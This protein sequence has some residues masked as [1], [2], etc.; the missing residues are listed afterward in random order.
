[1][2]PA[3]IRVCASKEDITMG[4]RTKRPPVEP[5]RRLD[6]VRRKDKGESSPQIAKE[7]GYDV[8]TVRKHIEIGELEREAKE[9]R[10][11]VVRDALE[12]HYRSIVGFARRLDK[13][14]NAESVIPQALRDDRMWVALKQH[15]PRSPLW[16]LLGQWDKIHGSLEDLNK[17]LEARLQSEL[18]ADVR[19]QDL[20]A[21]QLD[22]AVSGIVAALV[23]EMKQWARGAEGLNLNEHFG[24]T[25]KGDNAF[26]VN[27]GSFYMG[28]QDDKH[29]ESIKDVIRDYEKVV[30]S[31]EEY[32]ELL[33]VVENLLAVKKK[34]GD[35]L[36]VV[37]LRGIVPGHCKYCPL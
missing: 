27:Y 20:T 1:M 13:N 7:D 30:T 14:V 11:A 31:W 21:P 23:F 26:E 28:I 6:W 4:K 2:I 19:F 16:N 17:R 18:R 35:E 32:K 8:R 12:R 22:A 24:K 9:A 3:E 15:Q 25:E 10:A 29:A 5:E 33:E 34:L 37:I 36:A